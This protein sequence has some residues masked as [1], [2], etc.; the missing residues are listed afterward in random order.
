MFLFALCFFF[1]PLMLYLASSEM[2]RAVCG[3]DSLSD[4]QLWRSPGPAEV[5]AVLL[6]IEWQLHGGSNW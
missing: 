1:L 4:H 2:G 5:P 6:L 3:A